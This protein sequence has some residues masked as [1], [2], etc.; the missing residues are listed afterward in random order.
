MASAFSE[1][2]ENALL[3]ATLRGITYIA[4]SSVYIGLFTGDPTDT[5]INGLEVSGGSYARQPAFFNE[6]T[7]GS[8]STSGDILFPTATSN[9]GTIAFIGIFDAE[10]DGNLLYV[11]PLIMAKQISSD[12]QFKI[13]A[14]SITVTLD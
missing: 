13:S 1:Y 5:S 14:G 3:N 7:K 11:S 6:P 4:P 10:S 9:W 12:D 2:L 8:S